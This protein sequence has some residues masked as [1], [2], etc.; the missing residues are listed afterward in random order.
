M[1][2][3][4]NSIHVLYYDKDFKYA[5][6]EDIISEVLPPNSTLKVPKDGIISP[7]FNPKIDDWVE[8][9]SEE[10]K[11]S[12][13]PDPPTPSEVQELKDQVAELYYLI[14]MGGK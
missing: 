8:S 7:L 9:A 5:G 1:V 2:E 11:D 12:I 4:G 10:Y 6:E 14:A 3:E 13:K